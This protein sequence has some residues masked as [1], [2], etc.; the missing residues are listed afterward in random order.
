MLTL[1][2]PIVVLVVALTAV[3]VVWHAD[4]ERLDELERILAHRRSPYDWALDP[5]LGRWC[6]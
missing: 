2:V 1:V 6:L 3:A 4:N 5:E